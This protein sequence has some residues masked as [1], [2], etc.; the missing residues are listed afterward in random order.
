MESKNRFTFLVIVAVM[1]I[2]YQLEVKQNK[3][4][5]SKSILLKSKVDDAF[6]FITTVDYMRKKCNFPGEYA[7][8]YKVVDYSS[9]R[10]IVVESDIFLRPRVEFD[11]LEVKENET[12]FTITILNR[13]LSYLFQYTLGPILYFLNNQKLQNSLFLLRMVLPY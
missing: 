5:T 6:S 12:K 1:A 9:K 8:V 11:F 3:W 4:V 7:V 13:S 2:L 10:R